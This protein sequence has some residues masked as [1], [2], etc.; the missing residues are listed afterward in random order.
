MRLYSAALA[1]PSIQEGAVVA[2]RRTSIIVG[3]GLTFLLFVV[4]TLVSGH[5]NSDCGI[6]AVLSRGSLVES[7]C[8]DDIVRVG[9]PV[10]MWEDGGFA[11]H[12]IVSLLALL[13]NLASAI[14]VGGVISVVY[15]WLRVQSRA[16]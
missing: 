11:Y 10:I 4:M 16:A 2:I 13:V 7:Y 5:L 14:V 15:D 9:F 1:A 3:I 12:S 6:R 8:G